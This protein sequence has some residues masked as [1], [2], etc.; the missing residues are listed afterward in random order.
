MLTL[1][2]LLASLQLKEK[3]RADFQSLNR[4]V[5]SYR[6][7]FHGSQALLHDSS[8][9]ESQKTKLVTVSTLRLD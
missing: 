1:E 6:L 8:E 9:E 3:I 4:K 5:C 7:S 2:S